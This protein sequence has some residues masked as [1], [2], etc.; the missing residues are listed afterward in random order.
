M[1]AEKKGGGKG[2]DREHKIISWLHYFKVAATIMNFL[3]LIIRK[4]KVIVLTKM[5]KNKKERERS[6]DRGLG[7]N[8][9]K[10]G[11]FLADMALSIPAHLY[12]LLLCPSLLRGNIRKENTS[13]WNRKTGIL[14]EKIKLHSFFLT[15]LKTKT[16]RRF[17]R[18]DPP[19][20]QVIKTHITHN[21][22]SFLAKHNLSKACNPTV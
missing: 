18:K 4:K 20:V 8:R 13:P 19:P 5:R 17:P 9:K 7:T 21:N 14:R 11:V 10:N 15:R 1:I 2:R 3:S 12:L 22:H 6:D 16:T